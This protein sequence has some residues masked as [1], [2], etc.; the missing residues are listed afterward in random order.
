MSV[1]EF[2]AKCVPNHGSYVFVRGA[3]ERVSVDGAREWKSSSADHT[4]RHDHIVLLLDMTLLNWL[5]TRF[6]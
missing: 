4:T 1:T 6:Y 2:C 3:V 5:L